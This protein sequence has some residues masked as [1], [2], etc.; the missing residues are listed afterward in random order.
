MKRASKFTVSANWELL[1]TDMGIDIPAALAFAKLPADFFRRE[2][3]S[4]TPEQYVALWL[5]IED[6]AQGEEVALLLAK[7]MTAESFDAPIFASLCSENLNMALHRLQRYKPLIGPMEIEIFAN[8]SKTI[9]NIS[10]YGLTTVFP[11][12][13][14]LAE[15]AFFTQLTRL[16]TRHHV[17]PIAIEVPELPANIE[18][19][20][21]YFGCE[22]QQGE[23]VSVTFSGEDATRNFLTHNFTMWEFFEAKLNQK[24]ADLDKNASTTERIRAVLFEGLPSGRSSIEYVAEQLAMSKRSLQRRLTAEAESFQSVLQSV[25][26]EL[27]DHYLQKSDLSLAEISFLLGFQ[28]SN[29][30]I[31]AYSHWKGVSPGLYRE[32]SHLS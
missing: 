25:R 14:A 32:Q 5:G 17:C 10:C 16:A 29:S 27:A 7:H 9:L 3:P 11:A 21:A 22:L 4:L 6:V 2:S 1:F 20:E 24:L 28:E 12:G 23:K 13:L 19:Y 26:T 31:R 15:I 8:S 18:Q 30:F